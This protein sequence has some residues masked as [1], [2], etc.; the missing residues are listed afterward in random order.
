MFNH[1]LCRWPLSLMVVA[2]TFLMMMS[3][4]DFAQD[5]A[6]NY[7]GQM[8]DIEGRPKPIR[9]WEG[10]VPLA[11]GTEDVD[12]PQMAI[13]PAPED[14]ATGAAVVI[15]P[16]GGY[17]I[18][19]DHEGHGYAVFLNKL[20]ITAAVLKYRLGARYQHPAMLSDVAR[21]IRLMRA[22]AAEYKIDPNRIGVMGSSAGGH[23]AS[24]I[25]TH[26][27][28][29]N[30]SAEDPIEHVSSRPDLAIL[31][32]PVITLTEPY[33]HRGSRDNLIGKNPEPSLIDL[34]SNEK[35]VTEKTPPTFI[36]HTADDAAV[37]VEN[38]LLFAEACR[39]NKVPVELHVYETGRHGVGLAEDNPVLRTWSEMLKNW[40]E[41]R[42]FLTK[43]RPAENKQ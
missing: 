23:L 42:G 36:F 7:T 39:R 41:A 12:I 16:G 29:G 43:A 21:A 11:Q 13:Y 26:F 32:Y 8:P 2:M 6:P 18:L 17:R 25:A 27:D 10:E 5:R 4:T 24:T 34:L 37:P 22:R 9:L 1:Q 3:E 33:L 14:R 31:C 35:Q 15:C 30:L 38:T 28:D 20:G 19:A 40:L